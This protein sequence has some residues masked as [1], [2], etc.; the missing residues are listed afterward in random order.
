LLHTDESKLY[1]Q[2]GQQFIDHQSV[3]QSKKEYGRGNVT[4]N[5]AESFFAQLKRSIDGTHNSVSP[6]HLHHYV[7]EFA[8]RRT[9]CK[10]EDSARLQVMIDLSAG[11]RLTYKPLTE[12]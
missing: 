10:L 7:N 2:I 9:T 3:N 6:A 12:N 5:Q 8:F 1:P 11:R 4:T